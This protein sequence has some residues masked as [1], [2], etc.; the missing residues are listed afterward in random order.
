MKNQIN[1]ITDYL[2]LEQDENINNSHLYNEI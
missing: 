1:Q 2:E